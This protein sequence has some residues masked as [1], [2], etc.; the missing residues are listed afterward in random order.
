MPYPFLDHCAVLTSL[1]VPDVSPGP[2]LWKLNTSILQNTDY[3]KLISDSWSNWMP[4]IHRFPSLAKWC[5]PF[6][7]VALNLPPMLITGISLFALWNT[8]NLG[9][10]LDQF[11]VW[12][13]TTRPFLNWLVSTLWLPRVHRCAHI[14]GGLRRVRRPELTFCVWRRS[15]WL[16]GGPLRCK[17][18]MVPLCPL[19]PTCA[20][21]YLTFTLLC[22]QLLTCPLERPS[23]RI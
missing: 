17:R 3:V 2:G 16:T 14:S 8:S 15:V 21:A 13:H 11:L 18:M 1:S 10:M 4:S 9:L 19:L 5:L 20:V 7:F 23:L 6:A 12:A 22:S